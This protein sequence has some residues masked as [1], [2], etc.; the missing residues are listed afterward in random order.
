MHMVKTIKTPTQGKTQRFPRSPRID[1][2]V[3]QQII[4]QSTKEDSG[5]CMIAESLKLAYPG[6]QSIS[7]DLQLIRFTDPKKPY[8]YNYLTPRKAQE[9]L[10]LFDQGILPRA[11]EFQLRGASVHFKGERMHKRQN[12]TAQHRA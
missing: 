4:E 1:V 11:F 2:A 10:M 5:H 3:S 9:A 6:A 12:E 7:V 8:R